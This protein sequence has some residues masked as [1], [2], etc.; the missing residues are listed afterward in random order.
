MDFYC[1]FGPLYSLIPKNKRK[2]YIKL[3]K[4]TAREAY[5][6]RICSEVLIPPPCQTIIV[7]TR[8]FCIIVPGFHPLSLGYGP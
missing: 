6:S 2:K 8:Y 5:I 4:S 7:Q 3:V 1:R